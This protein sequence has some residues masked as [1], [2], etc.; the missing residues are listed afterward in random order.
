MKRHLIFI[1]AL[2]FVVFVVNAVAEDNV[3]APRQSSN[4]TEQDV[5]RPDN[6]ADRVEPATGVLSGRTLEPGL[7]AIEE[8]FR[9]QYEALQQQL[10]V[11]SDDAE[12]E[13]LQQ[14]LMRVK[15]E[16]DLAYTDRQLE[17]A[18]QRGD[19]AVAAECEQA[20]ANITR[21]AAKQGIALE[22]QS[23]EGGVR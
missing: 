21:V 20:I 6:P 3:Q 23:R 10:A 2:M 22:P 15:F 4:R 8:R 9:V 11:A 1:L 14:E 12:R 19:Q 17:L 16:H 7:A 18:Q 5:V 13:V